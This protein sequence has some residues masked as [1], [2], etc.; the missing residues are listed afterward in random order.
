MNFFQSASDSQAVEKSLLNASSPDE[1]SFTAK[2]QALARGYKTNIT[3]VLATKEASVIMAASP[4]AQSGKSS[5]GQWLS[6]L[7]THAQSYLDAYTSAKTSGAGNNV[8]EVRTSLYEALSA[9]PEEY[10]D[11]TW[12]R[13]TEIGRESMFTGDGP[14]PKASGAFIS[15]PVEL[16]D[17]DPAP[18]AGALDVE[19]PGPVEPF[20]KASFAPGY[21]SYIL[22][23]EM[24]VADGGNKILQ[25]ELISRLTLI[26][27]DTRAESLRSR[28]GLSS[29]VEDDTASGLAG[30]A[31]PLG[32]AFLATR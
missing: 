26:G 8:Q 11:I 6:F 28:W 23:S 7:R 19:L 3:G 4:S 16:G 5:Y 20:T 22:Q 27:D 21:E 10:S 18:F 2:M 17:K 1:Q 15:A 14:Q 31:L 32:A 9:L 13:I 29:I 12:K 24:V 25:Q 30:L